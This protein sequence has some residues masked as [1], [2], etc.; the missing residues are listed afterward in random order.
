MTQT[1]VILITLVIYKVILILLGLM[2]QQR[3]QSGEDFYLGG[4]QLGPWV[5][6]LSASASSSSAWT[7]LG[8]SGA[9]YHWGLSS[10]FLI[11]ACVGGFALNWYLLAK[12]LQEISKDQG[13]LTTTELLAGPPDR[14]LHWPIRWV[15]S[16]IIIFSL[17]FYVASQFQGAGKSFH[18]TFQMDPKT[19]I[20]I[21]SAVVVIYTM[22]GGFW[23]VSLTDTL[24]GF[25][26]AATAIILPLG[27]LVSVGG[28]G[29]LITGLQ[30]VQITGY[31]SLIGDRSML[32][33]ALF[34]FG[35]L[36]IG[37]GYP[38]QPHVVNRFMALR[39]DPNAVKQARRIAMTW[40]WV[41]YTGMF[42]LGLCGRVLVSQ[43]A[44]KETIFLQLANAIFPSVLAGIMLAAVLSAIMST[45]DSQLLVAASSISH[46]LM[47]QPDKE[48]SSSAIVWRARI[49]VLALSI[50]AMLLALYGA[51]EIF[52]SVLFAWTAMGSAFGPLLLLTALRGPVPPLATLVAMLAGFG[53]SVLFYSIPA[54][55]GT[56]LERVLP[57]VVSGA[58]A[59]APLLMKR[60]SP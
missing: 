4:R 33:G 40:A 51:K 54:T 9:A 43:I 50:L 27:A 46:D 12:P 10:V 15:A 60:K 24:Q 41:V 25:V 26:M 34:V 8:V 29:G 21:G 28:F 38:G 31:T 35:I 59:A 42:L 47:G 49:V 44:D 56:P 6:A 36:G 30:K 19:S 32:G 57:F 14:P 58:I 23:A 2:A 7:L 52:S 17:T 18:S 45:A 20:I 37:L 22:M 39:D 11:P 5:A 16:L 13:A 48:L 53:L 1:T 3:T 55:K